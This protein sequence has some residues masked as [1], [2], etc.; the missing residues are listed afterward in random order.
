MLAMQYGFDLPESFDMNAIRLRVAEIGGRFD[1]L[2]GLF[3]KA[4]LISQ[5]AHGGSNR[6]A[7]FY[8][9]E[10]VDGMTKF[11]LSDAFRALVEKYGR[12]VVRTWNPVAF[13]TGPAV[14]GTPRFALQQRIDIPP[15]SDLDPLAAVER[16]RVEALAHDAGLHTAFVG[17]DAGSWQFMRTSFWHA[18]PTTA[19]E[20]V[21]LEVLHLSAPGLRAMDA[22]SAKAPA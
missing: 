1:R 10:T 18:R 22:G 9:W 21:E 7:P 19:V 2:P 17:L 5:R 14:H 6:Y 11:L 3:Q 4:F 15:G 13:S 20:G 8:L 12:P 16:A